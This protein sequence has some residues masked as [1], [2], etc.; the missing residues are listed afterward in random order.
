MPQ[1]DLETLVCGGG[2]GDRKIACETL[3]DDD[4]R[5]EKPDLPEI[6]PD[7]PAESF[8]LP[9]EDELD[10]FDRNAFFER[11]ESQKG[12][13]NSSNS[14]S[15]SNTNVNLNSSSQRFSLILKSKASIIGL[16]KPQTPC[17]IDSKLRRNCRPA[18]IRFFPKRTES[19]VSMTEP[20]SPKVSCIGRVRSK[21]DRNRRR[22]NRQRSSDDSTATTAREKTGLWANFMS[23]FRSGCRDNRAVA[24][25]EPS[26]ES[27]PRKSVTVANASKIPASGPAVEAPGLNGM[28]RFASGRRSESWVGGEVEIEAGKSESFDR[29]CV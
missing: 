18:N 6:A 7:L 9:K 22:R 12:N 19:S 28:K 4:P 20:S 3:I 2:T 5:P 8:W 10:W 21:K 1:V 26:T 14:N 17:Y 11:K 25:E 13:S 24:I 27:P 23:V 15:N 29:D 16:P